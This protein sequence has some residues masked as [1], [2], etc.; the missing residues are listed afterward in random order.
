MP[1]LLQIIQIILKLGEINLTSIVSSRFRRIRPVDNAPPSHSS[2]RSHAFARR[3]PPPLAAATTA[4]EFLRVVSRRRWFV[5]VDPTRCR[6]GVAAVS[7]ASLPS[8]ACA[9]T[10]ARR[11]HGSLAPLLT[12][13]A[14]SHRTAAVTRR[15]WF[16]G[17]PPPSV[18]G[19]RAA[20]A[21]AASPHRAA[22]AAGVTPVRRCCCRVPPSRDTADSPISSLTRR[23]TGS[24]RLAL[25][26]SRRC[27]GWSS[28]VARP[29]PPSLSYV[30]AGEINLTSIAS[31]RFRPVD[32]A[33]PR[34]SSR[35]SHAFAR[36]SPAPPPPLA[37]AATAGEFLSVASRR[38]WFV[39]V[40]PTRRCAGVAA[41]SPASLTSAAF[42]GTAARRRHGSLAPLP[43]PA[44]RSHRTAAVTR[45]CWFAGRPPPSVAGSR[46]AAA[47]AAPHRAAAAACVTPVT[48]IE[49]SISNGNK[50]PEVQ[51]ST[52][53]EML[54]R[55]AIKLNS[56]PT[57]GDSSA[58]KNL[59]REES[60][61]LTV[62]IWARGAGGA[63]RD[64][65]EGKATVEKERG[66]DGAAESAEQG[67]ESDV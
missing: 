2:R 62:R 31:S 58:L 22:A 32:N 46:A 23:C 15:C 14:R 64:L 16:A 17:R 13:A 44:A 28:A 56:V 63:E 20:A 49:R 1:I 24:S 18:A 36:R 38:R 29:L 55:Q 34:R 8:A 65:G 26:A 67:L 47:G 30:S 61:E 54:M 59:Q 57:D 43:T 50:V 40:D 42:A 7:L 53:I 52:L 39:A 19:S 21:G 6:A 25:P 41:V 66:V 4:G 45:R 3:S 33:P 35:R 37:D 27:R 51:I 48:M 11:R 9:G 5:A 12:P 60:R 10:A